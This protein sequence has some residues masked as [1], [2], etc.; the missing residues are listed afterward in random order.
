M[1]DLKE[2]TYGEIYKKFRE[3]AGVPDGVILDYRPCRPPYYNIGIPNAIIVWLKNGGRI[4]YIHETPNA[5]DTLEEAIEVL[6]EQGKIDPA[7]IRM[8]DL[9]AP[10]YSNNTFLSKKFV[11]P[12]KE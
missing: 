6:T 2:I 8:E 12:E 10:D 11:I 7:V 9:K 1:S 4:I 3:E 5:F